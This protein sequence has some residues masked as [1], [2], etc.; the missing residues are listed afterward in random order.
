MSNLYIDQRDGGYFV[1][2]SRVS[3]D[4]VVYAY[5]RGESPEGISECFPALNLDQIS[6][7]ITYYLAN[8]H[9]V[10]LYLKA[11]ASEFEKLREQW[12]RDDPA[13]YQHLVEA[14]GHSYVPSA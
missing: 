1:A 12:K 9:A 13:F 4:S 8:R 7:A 14:R 2:H 10:D 3:L 6:G 5:L 11:S